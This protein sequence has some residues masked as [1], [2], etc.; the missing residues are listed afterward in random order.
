M[1]KRKF[2]EQVI[3]EKGEEYVIAALFADSIG[4]WTPEVAR[5]QLEFW[6]RG[7]PCGGERTLALFG[8]NFTE[9]LYTAIDHFEFFS[10]EKR[11]KYIEFVRQLS[12][13]NGMDQIMVGLMFPTGGI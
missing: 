7:D 3:R 4:Y 11:Q 9:E 10:E 2:V 8:G 5:K 1:D 6:K 13:F 12:K